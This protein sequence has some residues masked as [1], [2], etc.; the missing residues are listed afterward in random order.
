MT[1]SAPTGHLDT[2]HRP[3]AEVVGGGGQLG[4]RLVRHV[5]GGGA[6]GLS[7]CQTELKILKETLRKIMAIK[8]KTPI[9][10]KRRV[11]QAVWVK[12]NIGRLL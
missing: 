1:G 5:G 6:G 12:L 9:F 11:Q 10:K 7:F 4:S 3:C 8:R 2:R